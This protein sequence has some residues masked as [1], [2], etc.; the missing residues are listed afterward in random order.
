VL[1]SDW[2]QGTG[3][4]GFEQV[5]PGQGTGPPRQGPDSSSPLSAAWPWPGTWRAPR[6]GPGWWTHSGGSS[7]V[8]PSALCHLGHLRCTQ[9]QAPNVPPHADTSGAN[10]C[11]AGHEGGWFMG[12]KGGVMGMKGGFMGMKEEVQWA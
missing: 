8:Q 11:S 2:S 12:M 1:W 5:L 9:A 4:P 3:A 10:H 6:A 7:E